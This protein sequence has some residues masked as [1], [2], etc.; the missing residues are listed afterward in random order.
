MRIRSTAIRLSTA[1]VEWPRGQG[2]PDIE[3]V[4]QF[5]RAA[6]RTHR[7]A[8]AF[9]GL[10]DGNIEFFRV[11]DHAGDLQPVLA[12][13]PLQRAIAPVVLRRAVGPFSISLRARS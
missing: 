7:L 5:L 2:F 12:H 8:P 6:Q 9:L 10:G 4:L 1:S 13:G 3:Q 11:A